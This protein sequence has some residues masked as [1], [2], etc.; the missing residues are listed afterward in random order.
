MFTS[1][2]THTFHTLSILSIFWVAN[3]RLIN[4]SNRRCD[5]IHSKVW[6]SFERKINKTKEKHTFG[7]EKES[8]LFTIYLRKSS[9]F[10]SVQTR[11][12]FTV[13]HIIRL[14]YR[15][16]TEPNDTH[17]THISFHLISLK[18]RSHCSQTIWMTNLRGANVSIAW[19]TNRGSE[20]S[21]ICTLGAIDLTKMCCCCEQQC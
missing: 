19:K 9:A 21:I 5:V 18:V 11:S 1:A 15:K 13:W 14:L 8:Q 6:G 4:K 7:E 12:D 20:M 2:S 17:S 16:D 3:W 10:S